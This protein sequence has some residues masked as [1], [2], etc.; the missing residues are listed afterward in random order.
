MVKKSEFG[1]GD[2]DAAFKISAEISQVIESQAIGHFFHRAAGFGG[3]IFS[4][5]QDTF[6][7]MVFDTK[8]GR[9][10]DLYI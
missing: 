1:K 3:P 2:T 7:D 5:Q 10:F 8:T 9:G 4:F 6:S